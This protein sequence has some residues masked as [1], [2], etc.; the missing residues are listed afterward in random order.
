MK[1]NE[2]QTILGNQYPATGQEQDKLYERMRQAGLEPGA[3]YQELEMDSRYI[4]T[5]WDTS[6]SND[7]V[8]LHSHSFYELLYCR[9]SGGVEYLVGSQRYRL[10]KG[11]IVFVSPGVSHR[12]ILPEIMTEPYQRDVL[13]FSEEFARYLAQALQADT[14]AMPAAHLLRTAG[15]SWDFLGRLFRSG[16]AEAEEKRPGWELAVA[17]NT[18]QI[19]AYL[20]RALTDRSTALPKAEAPGLLDQVMAYMEAHL[21]E[22]ITL[23]DTARHCFASESTI[24]HLFQQKLGVSFYR[25]VTQRRLISAKELIEQGIPMEQIS[26]RV[27]FGDYSTFYRAFKQEYGISPQQYRRLQSVGNEK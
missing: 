20:N 17:G 13:W 6:Y 18:L 19:I 25:C 1:L 2:L 22:K 26:T 23:K 8:H 21:S 5:H 15:T 11:D 7:T 12:P 4:N 16:V 10:Q 27:G 9:S 14:S 24:S 3:F